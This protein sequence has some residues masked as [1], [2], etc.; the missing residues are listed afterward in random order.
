MKVT[1]DI[2]Q[3]LLA[4]C[5]ALP[6]ESCNSNKDCVWC[7]CAAVPS[8][9]FSRQVAPL[10]PNHVYTCE[11]DVATSISADVEEVIQEAVVKKVDQSWQATAEKATK[12]QTFLLDGVELHLSTDEVAADF[13]DAASPLSLAGYMNGEFLLRSFLAHFVSISRHHD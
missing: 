9:C 5:Q 7:Q 13:C 6:N 3:K 4:I 10:L 2:D 11:E 1:D 8:S 12:V